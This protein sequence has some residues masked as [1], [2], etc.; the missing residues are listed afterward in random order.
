MTTGF[1][2]WSVKEGRNLADLKGVPARV[3][4]KLNFASPMYL[5]A[6]GGAFI[7]WYK[8]ESNAATKEFNFAIGFGV[9]PHLSKDGDIRFDTSLRYEAVARD[10]VPINNVVLRV[11]VTF[12]LI[13]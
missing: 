4:A 7:G 11:G 12:T 5:I 2:S 13:Q 8:G 10:A 9:E 1:F 6:E 3:L